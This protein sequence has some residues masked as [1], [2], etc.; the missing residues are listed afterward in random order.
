MKRENRLLFELLVRAGA[1]IQKPEWLH[2]S[3]LPSAWQKD[4]V[5]RIRLEKLRTQPVPLAFLARTFV[6]RWLSLV[7]DR[8]DEKVIETLPIP[9]IL[10]E[11]LLLRRGD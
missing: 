3:R 10:V 2:P 9:R 6:R 4:P 11:F 8:L 7:W 1:K 5:F